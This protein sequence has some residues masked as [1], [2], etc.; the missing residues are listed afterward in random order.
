MPASKDKAFFGLER[1][2]IIELFINLIEIR[3]WL[4]RFLG[5]EAAAWVEE[6]VVEPRW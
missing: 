4:D 1:V 3:A 2:N 5:L 6:A